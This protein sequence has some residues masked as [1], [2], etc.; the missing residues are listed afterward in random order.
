MST[1]IIKNTD[2]KSGM[3]VIS[4]AGGILSI[5]NDVHPSHVSAGFVVAETNIGTIWFAD[6][7]TSKVLA[8]ESEAEK[9]ASLA[10]A[11]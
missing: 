6:H 2:L 4:P 10:T 9:A 5:Y 8:E 1:S 3:K 7:L 11:L